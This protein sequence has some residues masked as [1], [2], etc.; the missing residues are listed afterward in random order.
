MLTRTFV[1]YAP[2]AE[3]RAHVAALLRQVGIEA[4]YSARETHGPY[5]LFDVD[6]G[7]YRGAMTKEQHTAILRLILAESESPFFDFRCDWSKP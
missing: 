4:G 7:V 5:A 6:G 2:S 1:V 3:S